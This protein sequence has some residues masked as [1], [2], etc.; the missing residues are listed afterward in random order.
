MPAKGAKKQ[1]DGTWLVPD[2]ADREL[3]NREEPPCTEC[4]PNGWPD[5]VTCAGC[6][7]GQYYRDLPEDDDE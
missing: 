5:G 7:H 6:A 4:F 2:E 3:L 1:P